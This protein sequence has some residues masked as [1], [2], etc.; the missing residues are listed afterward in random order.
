MKKNASKES[1]SSM[2][3]KTRDCFKKLA[4]YILKTEKE[5]YTKD[6]IIFFLLVTLPWMWRQM[7]DAK[8][9]TDTILACHASFD[10]TDSLL[11]PNVVRSSLNQETK[12]RNSVRLCVLMSE[13]EVM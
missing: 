9:R 10:K 13:R 7:V 5:N 4:S 8:I 11:L 12:V 6:C 1:A 2:D 3:I